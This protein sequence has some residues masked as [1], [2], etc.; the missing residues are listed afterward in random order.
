[1]PVI[2]VSREFGSGGSHIAEEAARALGYHF[3]DKNTI[4]EIVRQ[5]GLAYFDEDYVALPGFWDQFTAR[6][7][8]RSYMMDIL[9]RVTLAI[10]HHGNVVMLGRG[11]YGALAGFAD[12]LDVRIQAPLPVRIKWAIENE[13]FADAESAEAFVK[14][15]E[16]VRASFVKD[17][18]GLPMDDAG[19]FDLVIDTEKV[20]AEMATRWLVEVASA[21]ADRGSGAG[22]TTASIQVDPV[23][24]RVA[25]GVIDGG[26]AH[27]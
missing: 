6:G 2:T 22:R 1:L 15:T 10:A 23:I 25:S 12:V 17:C 16:A 14:E 18:Y 4:E 13:D 24:A 11:C 19:L 5:Y 3:V 21:L 20:P 9:R 7:E 27:R 26:L 8:R